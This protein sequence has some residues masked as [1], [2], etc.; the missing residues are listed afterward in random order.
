MSSEKVNDIYTSDQKMLLLIDILKSNG[1][2]KYDVDFCEAI[3]LLKQNL[4]NIRNG[5]NHFT[6]Y[7]IEN[8]IKVFGI[9]GNW[10]FGI[11]DKIYLKNNEPIMI[12]RVQTVYKT[13]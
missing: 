3:G 11:S 5:K 12:N 6:P 1:V 4:V 10:I 13:Q 9:N 2:I 8:A 7:H